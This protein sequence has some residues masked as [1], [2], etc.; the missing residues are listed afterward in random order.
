MIKDDDE[1]HKSILIMYPQEEVEVSAFVAPISAQI[2]TSGGAVKSLAL[3]ILNVGA[4]RLASEIT[5]VTKD[6]LIL[7]GGACANAA[8]ASAQGVTYQAEPECL[9]GL[10]PGEAIIKLYEQSTGKVA[11]VVAGRDALD[12][13]RA[14]RVI[15]NFDAYDLSGSEVKVTGTSLTDIKV[16]MPS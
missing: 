5:D 4:A 14:T 9:A 12:T 8:T 13:R 16:S 10:Q 11:M 15:S 7:V 6:N 3:E 2:S 1:D